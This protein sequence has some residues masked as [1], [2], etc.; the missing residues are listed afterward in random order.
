MS[1]SPDKS[2]HWRRQ[3]SAGKDSFS[4]GDLAGAARAFSTATSLLPDRFEGW[5]NLGSV[6]LQGGRLADAGSALKTALALNPNVMAAQML[7]GDVQRMQGETEQALASYRKAVALERAPLA[8]NKLACA[9]RSR[10]HAEE[11]ADLYTEALAKAPDFS[12]ARVN[13]ATLRLETGR[14]EEAA[15]EL[16]A[17]DG[18]QLPPA[19]REEVDCARL[20]LAEY[21][22][23]HSAIDRMNSSGE[24]AELEARLRELPADIRRIDKGALEKIREY[25]NWAKHVSQLYP[26]QQT[27]QPDDWP[28]IE[29]LCTVPASSV[30]DYLA[31]CATLERGDGFT[32]EQRI[33][34][35]MEP[36]IRSARECAEA[37]QDPV[38]AE[39]RLRHWHGMACREL[40]GTLAG[41]CKYT[42]NWSA[43]SPA[44]KRVDP[45]LASAT[46]QHFVR[47][48]YLRVPPGIARAALVFMAITDL[49]CFAD[50][51]GRIALIWLN[52][53][54]EWS[55]LM[56][57][58]FSEELG[59][60]G[61]LS[62]AMQT[63]R[64]GD[65]DLSA[66][67]NV[68]IRA[69]EN[70]RQ[71]CAT[72]DAARATAT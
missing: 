10:L 27:E 14:Y 71:F 50:G 20:S 4:Q 35:N 19:E 32:R 2:A 72:L 61:E 43:Q 51:N 13:L 3:M 28:L 58:L 34:A 56:P 54:L 41:H 48:L 6:L 46:L 59:T 39:V 17:L 24:C 57:A 47:N 7:L 65:G 11:A 30:E 8:L 25:F 1:H 70:A 21:Q 38:L 66:L 31:L 49:N 16:A 15:S 29:A 5:V 44:L 52:R 55:G 42:R 60:D 22:R 64:E 36:A 53:E 63:A 67:V 23:L 33:A 18:R 62:R 68:I 12:L 45:H 37:M 40:P 9:L 69:Q 26:L